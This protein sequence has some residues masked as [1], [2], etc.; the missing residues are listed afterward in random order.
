M[1]DGVYNLVDIWTST[2]NQTVMRPGIEALLEILK[3][4]PINNEQ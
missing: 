4:K 1:H 3:I 2:D